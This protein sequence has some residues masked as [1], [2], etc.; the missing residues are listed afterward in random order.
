[1]CQVC[2]EIRQIEEEE[3]TK[4]AKLVRRRGAV[5]CLRAMLPWC[6]SLQYLCLAPAR[7]APTWETSGSSPWAPDTLASSLSYML[8]AIT[9]YTVAC[10]NAQEEEA[11]TARRLAEQERLRLQGQLRQLQTQQ[12]ALEEVWAAKKAAVRLELQKQQA[13]KQLELQVAE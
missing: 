5:S 13:A 12:A 1:M 2:E 6:T 3:R 8:A 9:T 4:Q 7:P 10:T 11:Q